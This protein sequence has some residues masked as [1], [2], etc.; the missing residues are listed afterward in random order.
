MFVRWK[1][2]E[3]WYSPILSLHCRPR[4]AVL[5]R[6]VRTERGPRLQ[7]VCYL[8]SFNEWFDAKPPDR[9]CPKKADGE[10]WATAERNL[11]KAGIAGAERQRIIAS[12]EAVV[13]RTDPEP[14]LP[15]S[16]L[17]AERRKLAALRMR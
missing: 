15:P 4:R 5:V 7:H 2:G 12:L 13:P 17:A 3:V 16:D 9:P 11:D 1:Y 8:G 10:F 6:S 14:K